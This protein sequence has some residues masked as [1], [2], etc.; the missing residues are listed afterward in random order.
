MTI[1]SSGALVD[2]ILSPTTLLCTG[3]RSIRVVA[4]RRGYRTLEVLWHPGFGNPLHSL[5]LYGRP[6]FSPVQRLAPCRGRRPRA[7]Q[8]NQQKFRVTLTGDGSY[9]FRPC[10]ERK[11]AIASMGMFRAAALASPGKSGAITR[12]PP[13]VIGNIPASEPEGEVEQDLSLAGC[14]RSCGPVFPSFNRTRT[15]TGT[16]RTSVWVF[17]LNRSASRDCIIASSVASGLWR[18]CFVQFLPQCRTASSVPSRAIG[19]LRE[20]IE[21]L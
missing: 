13:Q 15:R 6:P 11:D 14:G 1:T 19:S 2:S 8:P 17:S 5:L 3:R 21:Y 16:C 10:P 18:R 20:K 4:R 9:T 12:I 7:K